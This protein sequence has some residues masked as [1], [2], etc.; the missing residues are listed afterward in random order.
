MGLQNLT[1]V[2]LGLL[3]ITAIRDEQPAVRDE[4]PAVRDECSLLLFNILDFFSTA[5]KTLTGIQVV[6]PFNL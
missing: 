6:F 2:L 5:F 1:S 3:L 4:Q